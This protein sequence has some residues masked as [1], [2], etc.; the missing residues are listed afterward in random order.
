MNDHAVRATVARVFAEVFEGE[1]FAFSDQ[2]SRETLK[3]WD[4]LGHIRL[5]G[6]LEEAFDTRFTIEEIERFT[7]VTP[8]LVRL[9]AG[10]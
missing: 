7:G 3:A 4:S 5:I 10:A 8:I 9:S 1:D 6:A 2:L